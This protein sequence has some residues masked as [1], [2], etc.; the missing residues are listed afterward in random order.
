MED[1]LPFYLSIG[2]S[3]AQ[4]MDSCPRD[5]EPYDAAYKMQM[6]R[7][8]SMMRLQGMYFAEALSATVC[9]M[10]RKNGQQPYEYPDEPFQIF[11]LTAE[12]LEERKERE[13]QK[14]V[15]YFDGLVKESQRKFGGK[16]C[17]T[18]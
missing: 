4:F 13:L 12:E 7:Q 14:A 5:L 11:P 16:K 17:D 10:F 6:N 2:V 15:A 3:Y 1:L 9:N 8:N 18:L